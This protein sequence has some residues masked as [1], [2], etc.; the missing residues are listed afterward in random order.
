[1]N[2]WINFFL[3]LILSWYPFMCLHELGHI[4]SAMVNG[5]RIEKITL[6][7]WRFSQTVI[8]GS[9][10]PLMDAWMGCVVGAVLPCLILFFIRRIKN[11]RY[12]HVYFGVFSGFCCVGNGAYLGLGWMDRVGDA[13]DIL[14]YGGSVLGMIFFGVVSVSLGFYLWHRCIEQMRVR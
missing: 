2:K 5:G 14:R 3:M 11:K 4:L 12:L 7:P 6:L 13:G 10:N 1:M 9:S 8:S